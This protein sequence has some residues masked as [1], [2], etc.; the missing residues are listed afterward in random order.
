MYWC[1][2]IV[3]SSLHILSG[4]PAYAIHILHSVHKY[5][6][7]ETAMALL[8]SAH[9]SKWLNTIEN[10]YIQFFYEC[11]TIGKEQTHKEKNLSIWIKLQPTAVPHWHITAC[12][13]PP[14]R[15]SS[16]G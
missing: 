2:F 4:N 10:Y 16:S 14:P 12:H 7:I 1:I 15:L 5:G 3:I 13:Q 9:K 8:H 6:P 11:N